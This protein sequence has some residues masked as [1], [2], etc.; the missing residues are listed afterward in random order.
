VVYNASGAGVLSGLVWYD[1]SGKE[2]GRIGAPAVMANP[3]IAP[4]GN[5]VVV[6]IADLKTSNVDVW[7]EDLSH[8]AAS[9]FTFDSDEDATAIWSRDG[10]AI[11][12]RY[13][14]ANAGILDIKNA[15]GQ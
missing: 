2:L 11:A 3:S 4:E 8:N 14:G 12:Y 15:S 1:R 7:I 10:R 13:S 6:D 9:H 5:R